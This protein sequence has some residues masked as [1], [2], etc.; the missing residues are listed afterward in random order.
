Q[1][2]KPSATPKRKTSM[3]TEQERWDNYVRF[4]QRNGAPEPA[5]S[6]GKPGD[7]EERILKR[8]DLNRLK[9]RLASTTGEMDRNVLQQQVDKLSA[10]ID[11][12]SELPTLSNRERQILETK[13][14]L[15]GAVGLTKQSLEARL[16]ELTTPPNPEKNPFARGSFNF[17]EQMKLQREWP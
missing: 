7:D 1:Q 5:D 8:D 3:A 4:V 6:V 10:E 2:T 15:K 9:N 14:A 13:I 17:T 11:P 12:P 16:H